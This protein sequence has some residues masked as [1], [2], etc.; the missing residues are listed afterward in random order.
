MKNH[1]KA[2]CLLVALMMVFTVGAVVAHAAD[3][4]I[5]YTDPVTM[6]A[7]TSKT[8]TSVSRLKGDNSA[9]MSVNTTHGGSKPGYA[10]LNGT[11]ILNGNFLEFNCVRTTDL[12]Y[13]CCNQTYVYD[14]ERKTASFRISNPG[15]QRYYLY[16][17]N[18]ASAST[19]TCRMTWS[20]N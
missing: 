16:L 8:F 2:L 10:R 5:G 19:I 11:P 6:N 9:A 12:N 4:D 15:N 1:V 20:P 14:N 3:P 18:N 13:H 7:K 17:F